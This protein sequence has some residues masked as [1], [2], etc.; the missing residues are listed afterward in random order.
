M[1]VDVNL[2]DRTLLDTWTER[3]II[4]YVY[5]YKISRL[6]NRWKARI[7][8]SVILLLVRSLKQLRILWKNN[9]NNGRNCR[10]QKPTDDAN[11]KPV[12]KNDVE[13]QRVYHLKST[14]FD[15]GYDK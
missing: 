1:H 11:K 7:G 6:E 3:K 14:L 5:T 15:C 8:M 10:E 12:V 4:A 9:L 13:Q 2:L